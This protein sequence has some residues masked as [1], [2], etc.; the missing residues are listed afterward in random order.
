MSTKKNLNQ[1][2]SNFKQESNLIFSADERAGYWSN[3]SKKEN[4]ELMSLLGTHTTKECIKI[5]KPDVFEVIFSDKRAASIE[6]LRLTGTEVAVDLGCMWGALTIPLA[7]QVE[8][9]LGVDQTLESLK[10]SEAR[11]EEERL[12]NVRFLCGNLRNIALPDQTFDIAIVNG[13]LEWIPELEP[14]VVGEYWY[15][16]D[17]RDATGNPGEMQKAFLENVL[18]GLKGGGRLML[19]IENRY[20]YKMFFGERDPHTGTVLTTVVPRWIANLISKISRN[21]EYRPWIYSFEGLQALLKEVGFSSVTLYAVWPDY[22]NPEYI[23]PY[24]SRDP[25]WSPISARKANGKLG[26][27]RVIANILERFIFGKCN[28]QCFAPSIIAIA[29]K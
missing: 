4:A 8:S 11:A 6:L 14:V 10:F 22:R 20:D 19:A 16:A 3:L 17:K 9:V 26:F 24:G 25:N 28:L 2:L 7:K 18:A 21:R 27:R 23:R 5:A 12:D 1:Y 15:G 13:V 29:K